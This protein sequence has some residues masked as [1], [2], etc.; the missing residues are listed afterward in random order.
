MTISNIFFFGYGYVAQHLHQM[1]P[2][3]THVAGCKRLPSGQDSI[4]PFNA[5]PY[6]ILGQFDRF[7][8]SIPPDDEGDP[9]LHHYSD[10]FLHRTA[11]LRWIG[12][13]SASSVYGDQEG[14]W[15]DETT[16]PVPTSSRG[17]QR[18]RAEQQWQ[19][20]N[21]PLSIFRLTGI[22]GPGRSAIESALIPR[23][24]L[25]D[26]PGH[27]FNRIH[28]ADISRIIMAT[29]KAPVPLLNLADD[30]PVP[31]W[32]V[33]SYA[34][35]L[36]NLPCP[37]LTPYEQGNLSPMMR[38][39]FSENKRIKNDMIKQILKDNLLYPTYREGLNNCHQWHL[40][41]SKEL[42]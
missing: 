25:I 2:P 6:E 14:N 7:L 3:H 41:K 35:N 15:V 12:Y 36:L 8:I 34:Y 20:T 37:P 10:Y 21:L 13:L 19:R 27:V 18:L 16:P 24:H 29:F 39:F 38:D 32:Q 11:P 9:T 17:Q 31:L 40:K 1:L 23:V 26:K 22:Y 42:I 33:H 5:I 30:H 28:V 4:Y